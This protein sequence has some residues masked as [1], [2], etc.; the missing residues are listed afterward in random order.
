[1]ISSRATA[2]ALLG[3][4]SL[5]ACTS[6]RT[7]ENTMPPAH[8]AMVASGV[9]AAA[10]GFAPMVVVPLPKPGVQAD[11][12]RKVSAFTG[13]SVDIRD[14]LLALFEDSDLNLL[15]DDRV[16]GTST[17]DVKATTAEKAF[18]ALLK[19][20]D[21][22]YE[23]DD[24]FIVVRPFESRTFEVDLIDTQSMQQMQAGAGNGNGG[25]GNN[26]QSDFW[27]RMR[28]DLQLLLGTEGRA[29]VNATAGTVEVDAPPSFVTRVGNYLDMVQERARRQVSL[30]ARILEV[31]LTDEFRL[32]VNWEILGDIFGSGLSG[33]LPNGAVV[34][35]TAQ[36]AATVFNFG[37]LDQDNWSVFIDALENQGQVR[38]L[39]SP[40]VSTLNN[41]PATIRVV[42]QI[43]VIDRE[44][45]DST[46]GLRTQFDVRFVEAGFTVTVLPQISNDGEIM[47]W[48]NPSF[49][50]QVGTITTPDGLQT[51]PILSTRETSTM[52]RVRDGQSVVIGGLRTND[53]DEQLQ[54]VPVLG[55]IPILGHLFRSNIQQ[56]NETEL[57]FLLVPRILNDAWIEEEVKR[58]AEQIEGL[59]RPF[60]TTTIRMDDVV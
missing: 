19:H 48:V 28:E 56:R 33:T 30:E 23:F 26:N 32:G 41:V 47:A 8:L 42:E 9:D 36:S 5:L 43:P 34:N 49:V 31:R 17:F 45:I 60:V 50:E 11:Q 24:D 18:E 51:E 38:V 16:G 54:K 2:L 22:A 52:I 14:V 40:R 21:L 55:G 6:V 35:Q 44:I 37:L 4:S 29:I 53:K 7:S 12:Q 10:L 59:R 58:S 3:V 15:I 27:E 57:V 46:G 25:G 20:F 13:R 1:M 39:S